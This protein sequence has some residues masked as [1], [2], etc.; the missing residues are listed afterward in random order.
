MSAFPITG[1][2]VGDFVP[3]LIAVD[4][5]DTIDQVA[6]KVAAQSVGHRV[7]RPASRPGYEV[8]LDDE[9]LPGSVTFGA[10]LAEHG[11]QPLQWFD[12]RFRE[13]ARADA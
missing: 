6:K 10:V 2:F 5:D 1:R 9:V 3:H 13:E 8:L 11:C 12:V 4:T 7:P